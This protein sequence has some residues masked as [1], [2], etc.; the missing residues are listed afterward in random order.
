MVMYLIYRNSTQVMVEEKPTKL[1]EQN[2]HI[3]EVVK[4]ND[5][6]QGGNSGVLPVSTICEDSN[7]GK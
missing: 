6:N 3:I 4:I 2:D 7:D 1:H 5:T